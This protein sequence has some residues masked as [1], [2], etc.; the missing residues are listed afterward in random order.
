MMSMMILTT[1]NGHEVCQP[2]LHLK[3]ETGFILSDP[4]LQLWA[5]LV[6]TQLDD[7]M[8]GSSGQTGIG[9]VV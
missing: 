9:S 8:P 5:L 7:N 1:M 3:N 2:G 4:N 6:P